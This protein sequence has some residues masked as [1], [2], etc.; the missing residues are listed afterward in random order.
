M[1]VGE[2]ENET[3]SVRGTDSDSK[4]VFQIRGSSNKEAELFPVRQRRGLHNCFRS[5]SILLEKNSLSI[6]EAGQR[7]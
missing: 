6:L 7:V 2:L 1:V 4:E 5:N 3:R